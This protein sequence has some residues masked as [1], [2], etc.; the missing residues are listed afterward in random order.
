MDQVLGYLSLHFVT[1]PLIVVA[2]V[3]YIL[4]KFFRPK[5]FRKILRF[6]G[7][8]FFSLRHPK[9]LILLY[10]IVFLVYLSFY[11]IFEMFIQNTNAPID[12]PE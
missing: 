1:A 5:L 7:N 2:T 4:H 11:R 6:I 12:K 10:I 3:I 9:R 8:T